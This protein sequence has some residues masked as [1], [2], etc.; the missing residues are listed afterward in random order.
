MWQIPLLA[1]TFITC[2]KL[3]MLK[4]DFNEISLLNFLG[5]DYWFFLRKLND[6][7]ID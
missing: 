6:I 4:I 2:I 3:N 5:D 7:R 1:I